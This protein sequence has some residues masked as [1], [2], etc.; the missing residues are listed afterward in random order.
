M[1]NGQP[2]GVPLV[3]CDGCNWLGF[4]RLELTCCWTCLRF[5][6]AVCSLRYAAGAIWALCSCPLHLADCISA[7]SSDRLE[8][9]MTNDGCLMYTCCHL[10][11]WVTE[12]VPVSQP[13][14]RP[15]AIPPARLTEQAL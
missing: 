6:Y 7:K 5:K 10:L 12:D 1:G 11:V 8:D 3:D 2:I 9:E 13:A 4:S 14:S 15:A